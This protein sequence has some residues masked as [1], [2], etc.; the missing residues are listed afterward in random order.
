LNWPRG[1]PTLSHWPWRSRTESA[2]ET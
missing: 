1:A 2:F